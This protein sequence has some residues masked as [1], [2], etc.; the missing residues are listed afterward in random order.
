MKKQHDSTK[1]SSMQSEAAQQGS[2]VQEYR[3]GLHT[4][5]PLLLLLSPALHR[6]PQSR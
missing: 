2:A 6:R 5:L 1:V 3:S 4:L